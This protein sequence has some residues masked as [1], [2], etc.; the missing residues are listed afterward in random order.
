M[1]AF[2][3]RHL[4]R[5]EAASALQ[6]RQSLS[7]YL[8]TKCLL[9]HASEV[10]R[11]SGCNMKQNVEHPLFS[12]C[13]KGMLLLELPQCFSLFSVTLV[14]SKRIGPL[15]R[16]STDQLG[17]RKVTYARMQRESWIL[18]YSVRVQFP[19]QGVCVLTM[20]GARKHS[21][22]VVVSEE[23]AK[24]EQSAESCRTPQP[25]VPTVK[26]CPSSFLRALSH[27]VRYISLRM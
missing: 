27:S 1:C 23:R 11:V 8:M 14:R 10:G 5:A 25:D 18:E 17:L 15:N 3:R 22:K 21:L 6:A 19:G 13:W 16:S 9:M 24:D 26:P 12:K 4:S 7:I 2:Q 20:N